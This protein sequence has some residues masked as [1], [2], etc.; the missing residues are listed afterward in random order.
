MKTDILV[1]GSGIAGCVAALSAA[2][3]GCEVTI[4]TK[5]D[6]L[7]SGSSPYAQG[8]IIYKGLH[9]SPKELMNDI[10]IAGDGHC[11]ESAVVQLCEMGADLVDKYLIDRC[12]TEFDRND[13]GELD[14]TAEGAHNQARIIHCKDK[15]G[16]SIM[17]SLAEEVINH[18]NIKV[19]TRHM[20]VDLLTLAHHSTNTLDIYKKPACFGSWILSLDSEEV[21]PMYAA[22]TILAAGGLGQVY[23]HTTNPVDATGDGL[24]IAW[25]AGARCFNLQFIQFHPTAFYTANDRFL[26]SEA[27]RGE[28]GKLI[29]HRGKPFMKNYHPQGD[30]A[31]RDIVSRGIYQNMLDTGHPFV[32]LDISYKPSDWLKSRFPTIYSHCL[33]N[34]IDITAEPIPVVPAAHYSCGGVG[35]NLDGRTSLRR[36]YAVGEVSC[37]G[38]HGAN[39]L[40]STSL[41]EGV[42]WG[43]LAGKDAAK[44]TED[45]QYFPE[46]YPW[47]KSGEHVDPAL[48]AQ[49]WMRIKYTM[50][51]Y[52]GLVRTNARLDRANHTLRNLQNE[53]VEF[54]KKAMLT[55]ETVEL[56]NGVQSAIAITAAASQSKVHKSGCHYLVD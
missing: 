31:P 51:N 4:I 55:K 13:E 27:V 32:Y 8:G 25:R 28:G 42:V 5:A 34:G 17:E 33:E 47:I 50:W 2:D 39:R 1:I 26:I 37:T 20:A 46:I 30:L 49:D 6:T 16:K 43:H 44:I 29:D 22:N 54:Y 10:M 52:V 7:L 24:S 3:E 36:L 38:V 41:L 53:I 21:F 40:A 45:S 19:M 9:D 15:T 11:Q 23:V 48:I 14:L 35:V 12:N 18:P 56:R